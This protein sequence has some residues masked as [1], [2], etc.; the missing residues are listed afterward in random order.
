MPSILFGYRSTVGAMEYRGQG[1]SEL[2]C[3]KDRGLK[4]SD[5]ECEFPEWVISDA[6]AHVSKAKRGAPSLLGPNGA[7]TVI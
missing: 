5:R 4:S 3:G 6:N 2:R 7:D 1:K